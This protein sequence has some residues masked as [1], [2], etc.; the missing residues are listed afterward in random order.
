MYNS[1]VLV[2]VLVTQRF[3]NKPNCLKLTTP[4]IYLQY[5]HY[6]KYQV[7]SREW[8]KLTCLSTF[9]SYNIKQIGF[10]GISGNPYFEIKLLS[11]FVQ[12]MC[13]AFE[14][15]SCLD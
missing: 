1:Y 9:T 5:L 14:Y 4:H 15:G 3:V 8:V 10:N 13:K 11:L 12:I 7:R 6:I 2:Y